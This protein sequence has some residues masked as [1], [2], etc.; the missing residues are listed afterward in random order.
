[1]IDWLTDLF[2]FTAAYKGEYSIYTH[3]L[4]MC[5]SLILRP[6]RTYTIYKT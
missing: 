3:R 6:Q 5:A 2:W 1:M 4:E